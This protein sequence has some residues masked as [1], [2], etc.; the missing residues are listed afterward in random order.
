[1]NYSK[2]LLGITNM[3]EN[4][5]CEVYS[6][7]KFKEFK[8]KSLVDE[9]LSKIRSNLREVVNILSDY[10]KIWQNN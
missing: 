10:E 9:E 2:Y 7:E 1:M 5:R 6:D 8:E 4:T 3:I